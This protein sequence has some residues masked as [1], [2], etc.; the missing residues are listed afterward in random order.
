MKIK[1]AK[2]QLRVISTLCILCTFQHAFIYFTRPCIDADCRTF[3]RN[4]TVESLKALAFLF[5]GCIFAQHLQVILRRLA[6]KPGLQK[7]RCFSLQSFLPSS[8]SSSPPPFL[9]PT[10]SPLRWNPEGTLLFYTGG[11][12]KKMEKEGWSFEGPVCRWKDGERIFSFLMIL[13]VGKLKHVF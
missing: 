2:S 10:L 7:A 3:P 9:L 11:S 8:V 4:D 6:H 5:Y 13:I 12:V 1:K